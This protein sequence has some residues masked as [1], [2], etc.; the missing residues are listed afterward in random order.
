MFWVKTYAMLLSLFF[1]IQLVAANVYYALVAII[2]W[3]FG[4][5]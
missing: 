1:G 2:S 5:A 4:T 3:V